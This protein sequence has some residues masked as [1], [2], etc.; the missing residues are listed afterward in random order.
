MT[1]A[2][3]TETERLHRAII[4]LIRVY[5]FRDREAVCCYDVSVTQSHALDCLLLR[6]ALTMN[7]LAEALFLEKS[8]MS[9]IVDGLEEKEYVRRTKHPDDGRAVLLEITARGSRLAEKI[10]QDMKTQQAAI[11]A[12]FSANER[13]TIRQ[14]IERLAAAVARRVDSSGGNSRWRR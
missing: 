10:A 4:D 5:Q 3:A 6:G 12:D 7:E 13:R 8:T 11:F 14:G 2:T 1:E 9:R